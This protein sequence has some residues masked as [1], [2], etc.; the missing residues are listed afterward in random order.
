MA[1]PYFEAMQRGAPIGGPSTPAQSA[2]APAPGRFSNPLQRMQ[3]IMLALTNPAAFVQ[4]EFPD[5]PANIRNNPAQVLQYLQQSRGQGLT[6]DIP[7]ARQMA[8][9]MMFPGEGSVK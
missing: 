9:Q 4:Q 2:P 6:N 7:R 1:N 5:V 8:E 3:F